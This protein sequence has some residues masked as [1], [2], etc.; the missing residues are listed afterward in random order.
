MPEDYATALQQLASKIL[1][2]LRQP[3]TLSDRGNISAVLSSP[4][5]GEAQAAYNRAIESAVQNTAE[6]LSRAITFFDKCLELDPAF[7]PAYAAKA[8]AALKLA[9]IRKQA[10]QDASEL[11]DAAIK[12][13]RV[14]A[15]RLPNL[16]G[17]QRTLARAYTA[18]G[19]YGEAR[20]AAQ[21][22]VRLAPNDVDSLI[23]LGRAIGQGQLIRIPETERAFRLQPGLAFLLADLPKVRVVNQS[24]Y[25]VAV[26]FQP[27]DNQPSYPETRVTAGGSRMIALLSGNYGVKLESDIGDLNRQYE[28][29]A[30]KDYTL[31][32]QASD[33]PTAAAIIHNRGAIPGYVTFRGPKTR[34]V[35]VAAAATEEAL[36][37]PGTYTIEV[38]ASPGGAPLQTR[39]ENLQPGTRVNLEFGITQRIVQRPIYSPRN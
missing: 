27:S 24:A 16:T 30:G 11:T 20:T 38:S 28:F 23:A 14:G 29:D 25:D 22:A 31:T 18:A 21:R 8:D 32:F 33:V 3:T 19:R 2:A 17:T 12:D 7:A 6:G 37:P 10:G 35:A 36:V 4:K 34:T 13:A 1:A 9:D 26:T 5:A 15:D 39:H